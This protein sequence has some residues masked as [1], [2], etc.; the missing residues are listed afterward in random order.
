MDATCLMSGCYRRPQA[1]NLCS[2]HYRREAKAGRLTQYPAHG[3]SGIR[4]PLSQR[5]WRKI[6]FNGPLWK[7][8][9]CWVWM[10]TLDGH[11]YGQI[12]AMPARRSPF[13]VHRVAYELIRGT[14]PNGLQ[15]DHLCRNTRCV[16]PWH[17]EPVTSATNTLRGLSGEVTRARHLKQTHCRHGHPYD[18]LNTYITKAGARVCR[19]CKMDSQRR[20]HGHQPR[21]LGKLK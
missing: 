18:L 11:G 19:I 12:Y 15:I 21:A 2:L 9:P 20:I 4:V 6:N 17:L 7:G 5:L 3:H 14:I 10:G 1:R 13:K 8:N 16:N